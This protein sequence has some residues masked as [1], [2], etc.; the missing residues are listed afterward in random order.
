[1]RSEL[2]TQVLRFGVVGALGFIVDGG[3]LWFF[4]SVGVNP[5]LARALSFP[6]A[7]VVT[8]AINRNWTFAATRGAAAS[9]QFRKYFGVQLVGALTNYAAYSAVLGTFGTEDSI[10]FIGFAIGSVLGAV[11]NFLGARYIAF[12]T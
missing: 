6:A 1:M 3:L 9:G 4:V 11:L 7:V 2:V 12:R 5:Y 10:I 8:W